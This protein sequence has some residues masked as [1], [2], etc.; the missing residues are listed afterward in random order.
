MLKCVCFTTKS[1]MTKET[2][3]LNILFSIK[4]PLLQIYPVIKNTCNFSDRLALLTDRTNVLMRALL[5]LQCL[6]LLF[7]CDEQCIGLKS[8]LFLYCRLT[9]THKRSAALEASMLTITPSVS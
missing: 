3:K 7:Y 8:E 2:H 1:Q 9:G 6:I 4:I 5:L